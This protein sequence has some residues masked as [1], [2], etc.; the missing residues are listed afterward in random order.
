MN[1]NGCYYFLT[2]E[3]NYT[4]V[5]YALPCK[6]P[7]CQTAHLLPSVSQQQ[8]VIEYWQEGS[9]SITIPPTSASENMGK[10]N[11]IEGI[12]FRTA[13]VKYAIS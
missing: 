8:N 11:K 13:L 4:F 1:V 5:S 12:T 6:T 2:E 3:F 10:H 9:V 7:F